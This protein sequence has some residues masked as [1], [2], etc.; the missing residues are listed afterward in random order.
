MRLGFH[1][2]ALAEDCARAIDSAGASELVV[3]ARTRADGYRPPAYWDRIADIRAV[4]RLPVVANGEIWTV[5]DALRCLQVS[6]A[7]SLMLG[8]GAVADPGLAMAIR[9]AVQP[10]C[11]ESA[12]A[13]TPLVWPALLAHIEGF[14]QL[15]CSRLDKRSQPGRLKQW[16]NFLRRRFPEAQLAY[17]S[18]KTVNDAARIEDWLRSQQAQRAPPGQSVRCIGPAT[19]SAPHKPDAALRRDWVG[20]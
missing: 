10:A 2:D 14:W 20:A 1:D 16:L 17:D 4:V 8:R 19:R 13:A 15:V 9:A 12:P 3:H 11:A 7:A 6:G 5:A 18:L